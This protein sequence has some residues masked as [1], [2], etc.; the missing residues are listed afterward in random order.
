MEL[1]EWVKESPE[2]I[3]LIDTLISEK[4]SVPSFCTP[5]KYTQE[6]YLIDYRVRHSSA[7]E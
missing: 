5:D 1:R 3:E 7:V 6:P 2:I 4:T